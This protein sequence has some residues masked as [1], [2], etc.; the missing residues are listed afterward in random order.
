ML[1]GLAAALLALAFA[2][3]A[4]GADQK[5]G[6]KVGE[7]PAFELMGSDCEATGSNFANTVIQHDIFNSGFWIRAPF[8]GVV[9][10]W[11]V[12]LAYEPPQPIPLVLG[13]ANQ[14][15][16]TNNIE[17]KSQSA[18]GRVDK[19]SNVFQSRLQIFKGE[20]IA[21]SSVGEGTIP[22]CETNH[23]AYNNIWNAGKSSK[24]GET[25]NFYLS[26]GYAP[27]KAKVEE[28]R[29]RDGFGDVTQDRCPRNAKRHKRPC[30]PPVG[31]Q[32]PGR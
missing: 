18:P 4:T 6:G 13:V 16:E 8:N 17:I 28:D 31:D 12:Q 3:A 11:T 19:G 30:R 7:E 22:Y 23:P 26:T 1:A 10:E 27:V 21:L 24:V 29:D 15:G 5:P 20:L 14:I 2:A 32:R 25:L 9:S